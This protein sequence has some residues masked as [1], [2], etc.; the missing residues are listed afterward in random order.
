MSFGD[1]QGYYVVPVAQFQGFQ[2]AGPASRGSSRSWSVF[3]DRGGRER[4]RRARRRVRERRV[5]PARAGGGAWGWSVRR[6]RPGGEP[7]RVGAVAGPGDG[8]AAVTGAQRR[9]LRVERPHACGLRGRC[10]V[11]A[12]LDVGSTDVRGELRNTSPSSSVSTRFEEPYPDR[13]RGTARVSGSLGPAR[14]LHAFAGIPGEFGEGLPDAGTVVAR[15]GRDRAPR[16]WRPPCLGCSVWDEG[17]PC[18][19]KV[20]LGR[21]FERRAFLE[22]LE[23]AGVIAA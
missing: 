10:H 3:P 14:E 4:F 22:T 8:V 9:R 21:G 15:W 2:A 1:L 11:A 20:V 7:R 18:D 13:V 16:R 5:D 23:R 17:G 6:P 12:A 19:P